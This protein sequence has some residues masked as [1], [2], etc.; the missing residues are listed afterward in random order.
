MKAQIDK[1]P[2]QIV[3][4]DALGFLDCSGAVEVEIGTP[5]YGTNIGAPNNVSS[6]SCS[7]WN[8]S[9]GEVVYHVTF[10]VGVI[11]EVNLLTN[12]CDLDLAVLDQCDEDLGCLGVFDNGVM[13]TQP[14]PGEFYF[15]VD[16]FNGASCDFE[17]TFLTEP[18]VPPTG[19]I[20]DFCPSVH[21]VTGSVF[22]GN[23]CD[24]VNNVFD[25]GDCG[26]YTENGLEHYYEI[27]MP[28]GSSFA[29]YVT[30]T[31]DGALWLLDGCAGLVSC[32]GYRDATGTGQ[33]E[34]LGYHNYASTSTFVFLVVD[35]YGIGA[36]GD[37]VLELVADGGAIAAEVE[38]FGAVKAKFR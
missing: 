4:D 6:Y 38:S 24:G 20:D 25:I 29:A 21:E 37:Y 30:N 14:L 22:S 19:E 32:L 18:Y 17:I 13:V 7:T 15:V 23:S 10:P 36:C 3:G 1:A 33:T 27:F 35:A 34:V 2:S 31:A 16:G 5:L 12:G 11:W 28:A 26:A 8:E 9:G